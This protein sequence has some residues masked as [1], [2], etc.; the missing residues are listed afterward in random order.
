MPCYYCTDEDGVPCFPIYGVG[1]HTHRNGPVSGPVVHAPPSE[2]P[3]NYLEDPD[4][5][6]HGTWWCPHCGD[7]KPAQAGKGG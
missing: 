7:G 3:E 4:C 6:G 5:P 1:P 2:W